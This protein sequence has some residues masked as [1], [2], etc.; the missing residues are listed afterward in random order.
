MASFRIECDEPA[1]S[2]DSATHHTAMAAAKDVAARA[3]AEVR[4]IEI[5]EDGTESVVH[6]EPPRHHH[7]D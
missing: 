7:H 2:F 4:V 5:A 6:R 3:S 1:T